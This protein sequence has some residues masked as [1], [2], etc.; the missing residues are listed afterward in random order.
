MLGSHTQLTAA[1]HDLVDFVCARGNLG[2]HFL[3]RSRQLVKLRLRRV[4]SLSDG[5]KRRFKINGGL[6]RRRAQRHDGR[7]QRRGEQLSGFV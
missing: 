6:D 1:G 7:G 3:R 4:H 2:G 5:G